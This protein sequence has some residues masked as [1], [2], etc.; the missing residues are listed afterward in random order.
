M[1]TYKRGEGWVPE[2]PFPRSASSSV[3]RDGRSYHIEIRKP[4]LG[5]VCQTSSLTPSHFAEHASYF[6]PGHPW[7]DAFRL[8]SF[9]FVYD[10][11]EIDLR[12]GCFVVKVFD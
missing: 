1:L 8:S 10:G 11:E 2:D 7:V 3:D 4:N 12:G 9:G 6:G 5:E